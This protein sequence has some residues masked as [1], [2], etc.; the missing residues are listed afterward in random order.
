[1]GKRNVREEVKYLAVWQ[2]NRADNL[3][4]ERAEWMEREIVVLGKK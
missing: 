1:V 2:R 4:V 3:W